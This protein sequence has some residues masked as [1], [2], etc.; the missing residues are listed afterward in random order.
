[1]WVW[2]DLNSGPHAVQQALLTLTEPSS[3]PLVAGFEIYRCEV[4]NFVLWFQNCLGYSDPW[5]F[6]LY[7]QALS[8]PRGNPAVVWKG[9]CRFYRPAWRRISRGH[10]LSLDGHRVS[11]QSPRPP[12][13][14]WGVNVFMSV[15][16][17]LTIL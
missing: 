3:R 11:I 7:F 14:G 6:S 17:L 5:K 10:E 4:S 16:F 2:G 13:Q 9:S 15:L 8:V 12:Q 1:M